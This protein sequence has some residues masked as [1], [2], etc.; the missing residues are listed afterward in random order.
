MELKLDQ[1]GSE[2]SSDEWKQS[3]GGGISDLEI[4]MSDKNGDS[5]SSSTSNLGRLWSENAMFEFVILEPT[6]QC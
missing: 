4:L 5:R 1:E 3:R 6:G 2:E